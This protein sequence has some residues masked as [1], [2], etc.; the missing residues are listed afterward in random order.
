M[1]IE[2]IDVELLKPYE[3][4]AKVHKPEQI[5]KLAKELLE[6]GFTQPI[7]ATVDNIIVAGHGRLLAAKKADLKKV[8]VH[9]LKGVSEERVRAIRLFDNKV[10]ETGWDLAL[11]STELQD[12]DDLGF[13]L[14]LT[15]FENFELDAYLNINNAENLEIKH[16]DFIEGKPQN[17]RAIAVDS[18]TK[19][20]AAYKQIQILIDAEK[21]EEFKENVK[22]AAR[23][24]G[25]ENM[26]T[27]ETIILCVAEVAGAISARKVSE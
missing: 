7:I 2:L 27:T 13:D 17:D 26:N 25:D 4:N 10:A 1:K 23:H 11:L 22:K 21:A 14:S 20:S 18:S 6:I 3:K 15:A 16:A 9:Y 19:V 8:P 5:E 24:L 12:L